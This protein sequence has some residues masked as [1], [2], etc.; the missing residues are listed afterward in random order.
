MGIIIQLMIQNVLWRNESIDMIKSIVEMHHFIQSMI[1]AS[2]IVPSPRLPDPWIHKEL[3]LRMA[4][5]SMM[6]SGWFASFD[7]YH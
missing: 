1:L 5:D 6:Q 2:W 3:K 4:G 7:K